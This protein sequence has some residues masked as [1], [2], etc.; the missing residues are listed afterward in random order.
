[1]KEGSDCVMEYRVF[2]QYDDGAF[3]SFVILT[4]DDLVDIL[5]TMSCVRSIVIFTNK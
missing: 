1:M 3:S 4:L 5:Q 2:V